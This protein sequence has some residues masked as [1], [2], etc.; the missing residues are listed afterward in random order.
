MPCKRRH[1]STA[2]HLSLGTAQALSVLRHSGASQ[3]GLGST[4]G[5]AMQQGG[6]GKTRY[7]ARA[8]GDLPAYL[9]ACLPACVR[10]CLLPVPTL[11]QLPSL[12]LLALDLT[13]CWP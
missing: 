10:P 13:R 12:H 7:L 1:P 2:L 5:E 11:L 8:K 4:S 9:P 3:W 6:S